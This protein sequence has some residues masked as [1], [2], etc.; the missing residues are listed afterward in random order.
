MINHNTTDYQAIRGVLSFV[1]RNKDD[2]KNLLKENKFKTIDPEDFSSVTF[3]NNLVSKDIIFNLVDFDKENSTVFPLVPNLDSLTDFKVCPE[4]QLMFKKL[5]GA[6]GF[7][8]VFSNMFFW[9]C[10]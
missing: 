8:I 10:L 5:Y 6:L 9:V 2:E 1:H 7:G 4:K 3:V